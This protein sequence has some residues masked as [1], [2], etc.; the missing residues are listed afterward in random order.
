MRMEIHLNYTEVEKFIVSMPAACARTMHDNSDEEESACLIEISF[1]ALKRKSFHDKIHLFFTTEYTQHS[2][3][4]FVNI[5]HVVSLLFHPNIY[6]FNK[7][8]GR[9]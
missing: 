7:V 2:Q 3:L 4:Q 6:L 1:F 8:Y 9:R 5:Y